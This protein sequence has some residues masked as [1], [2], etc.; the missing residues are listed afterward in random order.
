MEP[1][2]AFS[3]RNLAVILS[4][5]G[6]LLEA[7]PLFRQAA[8]LTPQDPAIQ[9]GL[10]QCLAQLGGVHRAEAEKFYKQIIKKYSEHPAADVAIRSSNKVANEGLHGTVPY[11]ILSFLN[12][13]D[14]IK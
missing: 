6:K 11:L 10:A 13:L 14:F 5:V 12:S 9:L 2:N 4:K 3:K 8:S 1:H 7:L